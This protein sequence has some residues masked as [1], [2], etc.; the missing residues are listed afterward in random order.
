M[1]EDQVYKD[2]RERINELRA[3][4]E[5]MTARERA[6]KAI[7]FEE[8]DRITID[9]WMVPE[10]KKRCREYWGYEYDEELLAL[11]GTDVRDNYGQSYVRQE[12][13]KFDEGTVADLWAV[14]RRHVVYG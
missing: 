9:N 8:A 4:N 2:R 12:L 6:L 5:K 14:I 1:K 11:S 10:I 13:K 3:K 7:T